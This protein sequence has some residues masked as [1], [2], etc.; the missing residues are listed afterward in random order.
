MSRLKVLIIDCDCVGFDF[1]L[2][3][4]M[5]GHEVMYFQAPAKNGGDRRDGDGILT[6]IKDLNLLRRKWL[7]WADLIFVTDNV[8]YIDLLEPF[9]KMGYP[10]FGPSVEAAE[11]ELDREAGQKAMRDHGI[12]TIPYKT[13]HDYDSAIAYVKKRN[14]PL[15]SKPSGE[16]D[17]AMSYVA[18]EADDLCYML[19][20]WKT[21]PKFVK[22]AREHGFILQD[23]VRG[24][25]MAVGGWF[26]PGGWSKWICENFEHKKLMNGDLGVNT[27]EQGTLVRYVKKSKLFDLALK[28]VT[29]LL[30]KLNYVGYIDNNVIIDDAGD[31]WPMEFTMR[32][33]WPLFDNQVSLH[34]GDPAQ[35]M[36]DL[37]VGNDTLQ[38][39]ENICCISVVVTIPDFPYSHLTQKET[40]GIPVYNATDL[41]HIHPKNMM[42]GVAPTALG[43]KIIDLPCYV[44]CGDYVYVATGTGE[45]ITGARRSA[46]SAIKKVRMPNSPGYRTDIG[47]GRLLKN[48]P[49]IQRHGY[50]TDISF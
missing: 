9:R 10:I 50:A 40:T 42:A 11:L 3:C 38:V 22:S 12:P 19:G 36:V 49:L 34:V 25:E 33:G 17:K 23:K 8:K 46:Y 15:V 32:P 13:F 43:D 28:P 7:G 39:Q 44:T 20:R 18:D 6:K 1:G 26:G 5:W 16:A 41:D 45:T 2:R 48:I 24:V 4:Q 37:L 29:P 35:W 30:E 47:V 21:N 31:I 27:G 14:V